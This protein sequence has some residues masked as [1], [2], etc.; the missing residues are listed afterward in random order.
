M[1]SYVTVHQ[2]SPKCFKMKGYQKKYE[3]TAPTPGCQI[4]LRSANDT[5]DFFDTC[6]YL[7]KIATVCENGLESR[8]TRGQKSCDAVPLLWPGRCRIRTWDV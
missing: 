5:A 6:K 3:K 8:K 1:F 7:G 4:K 2:C